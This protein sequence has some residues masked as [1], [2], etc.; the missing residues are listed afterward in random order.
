[1]LYFWY[2]K[3][4]RNPDG[5][6][7][8]G[9][10]MPNWSNIDEYTSPSGSFVRNRDRQLAFLPGF[11]PP[12]IE[13][14][15]E[16]VRLAIRAESMVA[17]LKG[18][19]SAF[20]SPGLFTIPYIKHECVYSSRIEGTAA[21]LDDLNRREAALS[22]PAEDERL[23][24]GEVANNARAFMDALS[25]IEHPERRLDLDTISRMHRTLMA[26]VRYYRDVPGEFR[27]RQNWIGDPGR[28]LIS[29]TP[30]PPEKVPQLLENLVDFVQNDDRHWPLM[31]C[32]IAHYQF[33]A[34][35]PFSDGNGRTGR[36]LVPL[37]LREAGT[38]S[39][40]VLNIS[41]YFDRHR[42]AYYETLLRVS[43][44]GEWRELVMFFL[45]AC[46]EQ[47]GRAIR[48]IRRLVAL[49]RLYGAALGPGRTAANAA[50]LL[51]P[52]F[53]NP[54]ITVP[55]AQRIL[56]SKRAPAENALRDLAGAGIIRP[57][58]GTRSPKVYAAEGIKRMLGEV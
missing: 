15:G 21:S 57:V 26:G 17:E 25:R 58:P 48:S 33:E 18:M 4:R 55:R 2:M 14:D 54:Y 35:H 5:Q 38:L 10:S 40:P 43:Q 1:M 49:A 41:A 56:R 44:K 9:A 29:Y 27:T 24:T 7:D 34:I 13:I 50:R 11:L 32:A 8:K 28:G 36:L 45:D 3:T 53:G 37:M 22:G 12:D 39:E 31:R 46:I 51:E 19:S 52:L 42:Q 6:G 23:R 30:P 16:L 47:S 20:E